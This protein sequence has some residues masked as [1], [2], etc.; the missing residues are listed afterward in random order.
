MYLVPFKTQ[1]G[2]ILFY[3]ASFHCALQILCFVIFCKLWQFCIEQICWFH[4]FNNIFWFLV[5]V[6]QFDKSHISNLLYLL[7]WSVIS[8]PWLLLLFWECHKPHPEGKLN[9]CCVCSDCFTDQLFLCLSPSPQASLFSKRQYLFHTPK[10]I[11]FNIKY[12]HSIQTTS[13]Q[14]RGT[15]IENGRMDA[16]GEARWGE[17]GA[18]DWHTHTAMYV[19]QSLIRVWLS[20]QFLNLAS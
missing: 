1:Y 15:D 18:L 19:V 14:N 8:G 6:S 5:S 11:T 10:V 16:R 2:Y 9:K 7:R 17:L 20:T 12:P 4:L 13:C 3:C